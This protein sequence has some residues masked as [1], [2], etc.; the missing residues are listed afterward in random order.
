MLQTSVGMATKCDAILMSVVKTSI[1]DFSLRSDDGV[2][3]CW[4]RGS[5]CMQAKSTVTFYIE[6][7]LRQTNQN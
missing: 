2:G 1:Q 3:D 6:P 5:A 4:G 7:K